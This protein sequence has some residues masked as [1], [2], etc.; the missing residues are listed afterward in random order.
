VTP[1]EE[2]ALTDL[3]QDLKKFKENSDDSEDDNNCQHNQNIL[4]TL[5]RSKPRHS[6]SYLSGIPLKPQLE[7]S[8]IEPQQYY[9]KRWVWL[10]FPWACMIQN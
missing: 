10:I 5:S 8:E 6:S 2:E 1:D 4:Q 7:S 9:Y 3:V